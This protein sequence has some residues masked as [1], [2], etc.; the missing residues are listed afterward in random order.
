MRPASASASNHQHQ[1]NTRLPPDP[2]TERNGGELTVGHMGDSIT[3]NIGFTSASGLVPSLVGF[4]SASALAGKPVSVTGRGSSSPSQMNKVEDC[5]HTEAEF[6]TF[7]SMLND[8]SHQPF[9]MFTSLGKQKNLFQPSAAALKIAQERAKHWA[10][11]DD[12]LIFEP[13]DD[14]SE[15]T[16][17]V[18]VF[19]RQALQAVGN[20][21]PR[22]TSTCPAT[23]SSANTRDISSRHTNVAD[24][25]VDLPSLDR[26]GGG[27][28]FRSAA[29]FSTPSAPGSRSLQAPS[30]SGTVANAIMKP[31]K[32]P[33]L[34]TYSTRN[35]ESSQH[36]PSLFGTV[37]FTPT[38]GPKAV[39]LDALSGSGSGFPSPMPIRGTP[40]R[41]VSAKKFVT[42]FKPGMR[43]GEPG[44]R[45]LKARNDAE[46]VSIASGPSTGVVSAISNGSRIPTRR[47]F[48]DLSMS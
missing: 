40:M 47:R 33:L 15:K 11:E 30:T 42:P 19:P 32:S 48:F 27:G 2:E 21:S 31:F 12:V 26:A 9:S 16:P 38:K 37:A 13:Q 23:S 1:T 41:K 34:N 7:G 22:E 5:A 24:N 4:T 29:H 44:H 45:Q 36:T 6:D 39:A 20:V 17:D 3:Q 25:V 8:A 14:T 10:A 46:R 43:P 28:T 35:S 18:A